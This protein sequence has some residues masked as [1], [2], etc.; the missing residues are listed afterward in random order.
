MRNI[1]CTAWPLAGLALSASLASAQG[2][3][4][5]ASAAEAEMMAVDP[6]TCW[7][8]TDKPSAY[9]G[10]PL[11]VVLTCSVLDQPSV[12]VLVD[13]SGLDPSA[14]QLPPFEVLG[15]THASDLHT[16]ERRFF[17]YAYRVRLINEGDFGR[18]VALPTVTLSYRVRQVADGTATDTRDRGY[19]LPLLV[20]HVQSLVPQ[21]ANDIRDGAAETFADLDAR[22]FR[23]SALATSGGVLFTLAAAFVVLAS[24][25]VVRTTRGPAT[26]VSRLV[27][28]ARVLAGA[29]RE[30]AEVQ[31]AKEAGGWTDELAAR[32]LAALRIAASYAVN[33]H[34]SQRPGTSTHT[35]TLAVTAGLTART[36]VVA[37]GAATSETIGRA[38]TTG[39]PLAAR[40]HDVLESL[41]GA[42]ACFTTARFG[43]ESTLD[44][45]ALDEAL[46][47]GR[48]ALDRLRGEFTPLARLKA[49]ILS[50]TQ[51]EGRS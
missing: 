6:I 19:E 31:R 12:T 16:A 39:G 48:G 1:R 34:A 30:L 46:D 2:A 10:E 25:R 38:L 32:A 24:V 23:A 51:T 47:A 33:G 21:S 17:Q 3:G 15:G 41:Q 42:L 14:M 49:A 28:D 22:G 26:A 7:W 40:R 50:R 8:R 35:G 27:P 11:T 9:I 5:I 37:S 29:S 20:I 4:Q 44:A 45:T 36:P 13:E 18:D 43:R